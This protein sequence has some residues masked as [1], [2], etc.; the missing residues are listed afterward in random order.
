[1]KLTKCDVC[2]KIMNPSYVGTIKIKT[3]FSDDVCIKIKEDDYLGIGEIK[4]DICSECAIKILN[5]VLPNRTLISVSELK[6][7]G[8]E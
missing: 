8:I 3:P 7:R 6:K 1:M 2:G 5:I 4:R